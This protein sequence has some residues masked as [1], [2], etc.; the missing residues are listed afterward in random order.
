MVKQSHMELQ[1]KAEAGTVCNVAGTSVA[2]E[3]CGHVKPA[4][5]RNTT[6][7]Y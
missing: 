4:K 1:L 6:C 3:T 2:T 7:E 5:L